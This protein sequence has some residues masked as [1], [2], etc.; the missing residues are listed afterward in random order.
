MGLNSIV[1][2]DLFLSEKY[3]LKM[4]SQGSH[5]L[6]NFYF[7]SEVKVQSASLLTIKVEHFYAVSQLKYHT[8]LELQHARDIRA[9]VETDFT[10][11]K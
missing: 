3:C 2:N 4:S 1:F 8:F 5:C 9:T 7:G 10:F 6:L 11:E